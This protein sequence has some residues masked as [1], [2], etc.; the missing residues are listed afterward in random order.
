MLFTFTYNIYI[1]IYI[2]TN[3]ELSMDK[4]LIVNMISDIHD[5]IEAIEQSDAVIDV[6]FMPNSNDTVVAELEAIIEK[7]ED[8]LK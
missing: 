1:I 7:L 5:I 8:Q 4:H 2:R 6:I 3:R